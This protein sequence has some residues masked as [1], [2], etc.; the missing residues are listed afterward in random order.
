MSFR[1]K[2]YPEV[3]DHLLNRL[4]GGVSGEAHPYPP[5]GTRREPYAHALGKSPAASVTSVYGLL[6]GSS[7]AF[8]RGADY[9]LSS[10][11][12]KVVWKSGQRP[13]AGS[14]VEINY[15]PK[16]RD[17]PANDLYPGS[18]TRTLVETVSLEVAGLYAQLEAVYR[19]AFINTAEGSA[20]DHVVSLLG[21]TRVRAG[22]NR[23]EVE[24]TR[25]PGSR[26]EIL[27]PS[28]TR[29]RTAD[30]AI[31]YETLDDIAVSDGQLAARGAARDTVAT[32]DGVVAGALALLPKPIAGISS[33]SNPGPS[34]RLER[35][36]SDAELRARAK[37]FLSGSERGTVGALQAAVAAEGV[38][39][40]ILEPSPGQIQIV[41]F[42]DRLAPEQKRRLEA[43]V[44]A[45]R[46]AGIAVEFVYGSPPL[47]VDIALRLSTASGLLP[48]EL[49]AIQARVR[50]SVADY[51]ARLPTKAAGSSTRLIGLAMSVAGVEDV[52][53]VSAT[54]SG[55][56]VL[57]VATGTL[58]IA[59]TPT[60]LGTL[61]L[62]DPALAS[63]LRVLVRHPRD[64]A[65]PVRA[66]VEAAFAAALSYLNEANQ[67][68]ALG[69]TARTL[70]WQKLALITPLPD[71][72]APSLVALDQNPAGFVLPTATAL[73]PYSLQFVLERPN[74]VSRVLENETM[75][76][77]E[78]APLERL[79][80]GTV[81][82]EVKPKAQP[83]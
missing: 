54:V 38:L 26:G 23:A 42:D 32:N 1:R 15:L 24:F 62:L 39:A 47:E 18:V 70:S 28:G 37:S 12:A 48:P 10:D 8:A 66:S 31:E 56:S 16:Q 2:T 13:D 68:P 44:H 45:V 27:I 59:G 71:A 67:S 77:F 75:P 9:E 79:R 35:D 7:H 61:T 30:G 22:H 74:G 55:N 43:R 6:N 73:E 33:V 52:Q 17:V 36:E 82:V 5:A 78:L 58:A 83:V 63:E 34:S 64:A 69:S 53:V 20:L 29:V 25:A 60:R 11:G 14:V 19:S 4:L 3:T 41:F 72:A 57:E 50:D 81:T 65:I 21:L 80:L 40:D 51:F 46:P 49:L 76:A